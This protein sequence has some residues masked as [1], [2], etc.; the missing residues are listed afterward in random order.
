MMGALEGVTMRPP[1]A[2]AA[3]RGKS[4]WA[5]VL[6]RGQEMVMGTKPGLRATTRS[7]CSG[8]AGIATDE[9]TVRRLVAEPP[10]HSTTTPESGLR[11]AASMTR[12]SSAVTECETT[13]RANATSTA[14]WLYIEMKT[15]SPGE[16]KEL[17]GT[18]NSAFFQC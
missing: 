5:G 1:T 13:K 8:E 3:G 10:V 9:S 15:M 17:E 2:R 16:T 18:F 14:P 4:N 7:W 12:R 11:S 6:P